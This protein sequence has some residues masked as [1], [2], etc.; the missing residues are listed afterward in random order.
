MLTRLHKN[1]LFVMLLH[2]FVSAAAFAASV[3]GTRPDDPKAVQLTA[4]A[5]GA[6][7]D[8][9]SDDSAAIQAAIDK[10]AENAPEGIVFVGPGQYRL[11]RTV[12]VWPGVRL[13]GYGEPEILAGQ[14]VDVG[15]P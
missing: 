7:A 11:T 10:A 6:R 8:G 15:L 3:I 4:P 13:F 2:G 5:F 12:Y 9:K 14:I 1:R